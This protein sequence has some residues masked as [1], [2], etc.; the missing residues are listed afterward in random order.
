ML[1]IGV[2]W[3]SR[4]G[5]FGGVL[6]ETGTILRWCGVELAKRTRDP[7]LPLTPSTGDYT[8]LYGTCILRH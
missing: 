3:L 2:G 5:L 4:I 7:A 6:R 8:N 1:S